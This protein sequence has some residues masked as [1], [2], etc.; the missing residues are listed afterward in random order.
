MIMS[1]RRTTIKDIA[2]DVGVSIALVSFVMNKKEKH[3]RVSEE[4]TVRIQEAA[5]RLN[6]QPNNAARSLRNGRTRT[7]GVVVSDISNSFFADIARCIEDNAYKANYTVI[8]GSTD[9][10]AE[11]LE[12]VMQVLINKGVDGLIVVPCEGSEQIIAKMSDGRLPIVLLDRYITDNDMSRVVLNNRK[13]T[14]MAVEHL[15]ER[16]YKRISMISYAM[17]LTN[18]E[19]REAGYMAAMQK[20]GL[21]SH[22]DIHKIGYHNIAQQVQQAIEKIATKGA[23]AVVFGTNTLTIQGLKHMRKINMRVPV[24]IAVVGFDGSDAFELFYASIT[25][26]KQPIEQIGREAFN[27]I[28]KSIEESEA[29][30]HSVVTLDPELILGDSTDNNIS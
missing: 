23:D 2:E 26:I 13:A 3:Y 8:F 14:A 5:K 27:L 9:E 17:K 29:M 19:E 10:N 1:T 7:I 20:L 30:I 6:Y 18:V 22:I 21:Q 16:G 12:N 28:I 15:A 24:D 25:H 11:K 4:M